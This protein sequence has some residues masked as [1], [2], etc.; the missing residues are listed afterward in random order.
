M[1]RRLRID[2]GGI[3]CHGREGGQAQFLWPWQHPLGRR[4]LGD[5]PALT[6]CL[7]GPDMERATESDIM[8]LDGDVD[9]EDGAGFLNTVTAP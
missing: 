9:L 2:R 5:L 4:G 6:D 3:A 1:A 8:D 7:T